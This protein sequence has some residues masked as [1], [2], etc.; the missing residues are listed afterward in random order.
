MKNALFKEDTLDIQ[1]DVSVGH[2]LKE[3]REA[4]GIPLEIVAHNLRI[5]IAHLE[6]LEADHET[7]VSDVYTLGFL[8]IYAKFLNLNA[9][10]LIQK[11]K[12]QF[13]PAPPSCLIFPTPPAEQGIAGTRI[14][15]WSVGLF[16]IIAG[17]SGYQWWKIHQE[18]ISLKE[19]APLQE[20][21]SV[22]VAPEPA[23]EQVPA[24]SPISSLTEQGYIP[25]EL[26]LPTPIE[27]EVVPP[28]E[29]SSTFLKAI[30]KTWIDVRD[31]EGKIIVRRL[32]YTGQVFELKHPENL[33]L[34]VGNAQGIQIT[35]GKK[36]LAF[37]GVPGVK[38]GISLNSSNWN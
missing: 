34:K 17:I 1:E 33:V 19:V 16:I 36:T 23:T 37:P 10:A 28:A 25:E 13:A 14:L 29:S 26:S 31:R 9:N 35:S 7:L 2:L 6:K 30:E 21:P 3:H 27:E 8:R 38:S 4:L 11:F 18:P 22:S 15:L 12:K 24:L 20:T 5:G 32:L